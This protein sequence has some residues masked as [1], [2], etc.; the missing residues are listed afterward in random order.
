M[1]HGLSLG[2]WKSSSVISPQYSS[3]SFPAW[4]ATVT[5]LCGTFSHSGLLRRHALP[6]NFVMHWSKPQPLLFLS[7]MNFSSILFR[8]GLLPPWLYSKNSPLCSAR[9]STNKALLMRPC[10]KWILLL[11]RQV[12]RL[13]WF[14]SDAPLVSEYKQCEFRL[15]LNEPNSYCMCV[16]IGS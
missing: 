4:Q 16:C 2:A 15:V 14:H 7:V 11:G 13:S 6:G 1:L 12:K 10:V 5:A 9:P 8:N 3:Y